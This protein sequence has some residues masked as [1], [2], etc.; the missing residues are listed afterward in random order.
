[1][2]TE[3]N[4]GPPSAIT[5]AFSVI[6]H[7]LLL[8]P[9]LYILVLAFGKYSFFAWHPICMSVG[10]SRDVDKICLFVEDDKTSLESN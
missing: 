6:T 8:A 10:V 4:K 2:T 1:M 3:S 5:L 9:V 7:F